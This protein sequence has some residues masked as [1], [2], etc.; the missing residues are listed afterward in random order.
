MWDTAPEYLRCYNRF[1]HLQVSWVFKT[2]KI[3]IKF[4]TSLLEREKVKCC[5]IFDSQRVN[6]WISPVQI[7]PT[8][9]GITLLQNNNGELVPTR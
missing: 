8:K 1:V 9:Y 3:H 2:T 5:A 4:L 6:Q 7:V